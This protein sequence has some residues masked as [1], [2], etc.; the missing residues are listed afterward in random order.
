MKWVLGASI[1]AIAMGLAATTTIPA[2]SVSIDDAILKFLPPETQGIVFIDV[3]ALRNASLVRDVLKDQKL[4]SPRGW[5]DFVQATGMVPERDIDKVTI[6][7]LDAQDG[8]VIIQGRIDKFK[9]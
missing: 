4:T 3:A 5:G 7:K 9:I 8:L 6:G 1:F 2:A